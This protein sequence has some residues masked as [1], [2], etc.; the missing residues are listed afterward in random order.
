MLDTELTVSQPMVLS[1]RVEE[2][3]FNGLV[4]TITTEAERVCR[5]LLGQAIRVLE[6]RAM[7]QQP[8][9]WVNRGQPV[10]HVWMAWGR[11]AIRRTRVLDRHTGKTYHLGDHLLRWRPYVRRSV[12][13]VRMGCELAASMSYPAA[14]HWWKRLTGARSSVMHFWRMVQG[15]GE[16]LVRQEWGTG[17]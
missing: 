5:E 6:R 7:A 3:D 16:R 13:A 1:V 14:L 8:G 2:L 11:T 15:A 17:R 12:E 4:R 10:R 9:R